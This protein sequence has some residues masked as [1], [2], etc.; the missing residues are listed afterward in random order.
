MD[1]QFDPRDSQA[2]ES[3]LVR[4]RPDVIV[5]LAAATDVNHCEARPQW[6]Y[7]ANVGPVIGLRRA[8]GKCG[9]DPHLVHISTDQI[10]DG[11]GPHREDAVRPCNVYGLSKLAGELVAREIPSTVLRTNFFGASQTPARRSFSDWIV[12]SLRANRSITVFEDVFF[13]ALHMDC[14]CDII[15]H[16]IEVRPCATINVGTA[17]GISKADFA[18]ALAERLNLPTSAMRKGSI[19]DARLVARRP[20]DMR[21]DMKCF[22]Q[23]FGIKA[24]SMSEQI[25]QTSRDYSA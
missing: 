16:A 24:P 19:E 13:S 22:E 10:Y 5:N 6:A 18:L 8:A 15:A 21:M 11:E 7:D 17:D 14:L 9:Q 23:T 1:L 20:L 3:V 12:G 4:E 2:W 25:D